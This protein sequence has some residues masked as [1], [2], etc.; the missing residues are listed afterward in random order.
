[1]LNLGSKPESNLPDVD[2]LECAMIA[3]EAEL[4]MMIHIDDL[5]KYENAIDTIET[6]SDI[7]K[8]I[9]NSMEL[10]QQ[11]ISKKDLSIM[12][13]EEL[14]ISLEGVGIFTRFLGGI[15]ASFNAYEDSLN[16]N[17]TILNELYT[18]TSK[19]LNTYSNAKFQSARSW[20]A[21][22]PKRHFDDFMNIFIHLYKEEIGRAHV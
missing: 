9:P 18:E 20:S 15:K 1:M 22:L 21:V 4:Q 6:I 10:L 7:K 14:M 16:N 19:K 8:T 3:A 17:T 5:N 11:L 12:S 2:L 13:N